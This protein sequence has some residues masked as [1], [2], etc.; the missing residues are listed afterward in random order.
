MRLRRA[1][2]IARTRENVYHGVESARGRRTPDVEFDYT[3]S[4]RLRRRCGVCD[5]LVVVR[6][7]NRLTGHGYCRGGG[8]EAPVL[9]P[10]LLTDPVEAPVASERPTPEPAPAREPYCIKCRKFREEVRHAARRAVQPK[11]THVQYWREM[12]ERQKAMLAEHRRLE[13]GD[14]A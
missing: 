9:P 12:A 8:D 14:P 3:E 1:T 2:H 11:A 6:K 10:L 13:H 5:E 7:D 4:G